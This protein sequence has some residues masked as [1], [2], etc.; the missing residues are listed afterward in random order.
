MYIGTNVLAKV[1]SF[2][3]SL[4]L[5]PAVENAS[6]SEIENRVVWFVGGKKI[7]VPARSVIA[8]SV[9]CSAY[10]VD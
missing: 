5:N 6:E 2:R 10:V 7:H 1:P 8:L 9:K 3:C 4:K